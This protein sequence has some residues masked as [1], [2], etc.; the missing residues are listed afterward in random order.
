MRGRKKVRGQLVLDTP[1]V[2]H[3]F[4]VNDAALADHVAGHGVT[5]PEV[6]FLVGL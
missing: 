1:V 2:M 3:R 5:V 6:N 4:F